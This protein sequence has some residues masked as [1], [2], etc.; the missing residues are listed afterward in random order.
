MKKE[1]L[2]RGEWISESELATSLNRLEEVISQD[3][4]IKF[5]PLVL[6]KAAEK[7]KSDIEK[8]V[9]QEWMASLML[10]GQTEQA[11]QQTISVIA[12][13]FNQDDLKKKYI[14]ELGSLE[15]FIP[16]RFDFKTNVFEAWAPLGALVHI[17]PGNAATVAPLSVLEGLMSGNI[18]LLKNSSKNGNFPQL[19]LK[20]LVDADGTGH[21][22]SFVYAFQISS[23]EEV[24]LGKLYQVANG[25]AAWGGEE[26]VAAVKK[27]AAPSVR[28]IDWGHKISFSYVAKSKKDDRPSLEAIAYDICVIEQQACSSPQCL[29]LDTDD[30]TELDEFANH[31]SEILEQVSNTFPQKNPSIQESAEISGI[32]QVAR[33]SEALGESK[34]IES[35][36]HIWRIIVDYK[37]SL[38]PSPLYRTIWVK[39][40]SSNKIVSVLEPF[41]TYLQSAGLACQREEL[42][43]LSTKLFQAGVTRVMPPGKMLNGYA[44]QP[45]DGVYALQR[46]SR[47]ISLMA[48]ELTKDISDFS[49][50]KTQDVLPFSTNTAVTTKEDYLAHHISEENAQLFFKSGGTTGKPKKAVYTYDDYHVQMKA[51]AEALFSAGLNPETDR[52]ANLFY[53]GHMYGGFISFWSI[54]EFLQAKQFPIT[55]IPDF[56]Q[57]TESIIDN[58]ID[59]LLGMPF[60]LSQLFEHSFEELKAY[61]GLEKIFYGGE[62]WPE[63]QCIKYQKAFGI[64]MFKSAVYGS[65][66]AGPLGYA[67]SHTQ[68]SVHH[69]LTQTQYLEI[70]ELDS[71]KPVEKGEVGRLI[72]T[73][74]YRKGQN[75]NR[76]EIGDLGR[77]IEGDCP[78]GRK[79][80]RFE[81]L[82]R[83]GDIFKMGPLFNYNEFVAVLEKEFHYA[84]QLQLVLDVADDGPQSILMRIEQKYKLKETDVLNAIRRAFPTIDVVNENQV[85]IDLKVD[86][87]D[88]EQFE[89]VSTTGK[90][91]RIIDKRTL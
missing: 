51:G 67:C 68:G 65:N 52:C 62:H 76:Y 79:A 21:L 70:L 35:N 1:H 5:N 15:P 38:R 36:D 80:P 78:C 3:L 87:I 43:D 54:L 66:D 25:I 9:P 18:N 71:L 83:F 75:L 22:K 85:L 42:Y 44:G 6:L 39:P 7:V 89:Q 55:A 30:Q 27:M 14:R 73:S 63:E 28:I 91:K 31:F 74:K 86:F 17:V 2:Y 60:Y 48:E 61:G 40:L 16:K 82:G 84:G 49:E 10:S 81:L 57:L 77:W 32:T 45:H 56:D 29:Y 11:A 13:F 4:S 26:S 59:T 8:E 90:L 41:R 24:L 53:S 64:E 12:N 88:E 69:L 58:K 50:L 19:V 37:S 20:A 47:R 72:F 33:T 34:V 23:K 46:Y